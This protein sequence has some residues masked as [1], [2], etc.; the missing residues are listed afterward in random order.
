VA[1]QVLP[2]VAGEASDLTMGR[3]LTKY[4]EKYNTAA[5]G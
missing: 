5:S 4:R 2:G 1:A 3:D